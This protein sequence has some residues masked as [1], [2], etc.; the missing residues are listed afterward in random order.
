MTQNIST[1]NDLV[2]AN[3]IAD[4]MRLPLIKVA[5]K[6]KIAI[7]S[8]LIN[9]IIHKDNSD[10]IYK[11]F[12]PDIR[13][14]S[15]ML[16]EHEDPIGDEIH[17]PLTG[18]VHRYKNRVLIKLT[19]TCPI[20]CRF[21]FRREMVGKPENGILN[22][23]ELSDIYDYLKKHIEINEVIFTGGDPLILSPM[24]LGK[25]C[26]N[27]HEI[28]HIKTLRIHSRVVTALPKRINARLISALKQSEKTL[29]I[30]L[31]INHPNEL[32][33][34]AISKIQFLN[35]NNINLLSQTVLLAGVN[36]NATVLAQLMCQFI[37][38]GVRPYYIHHP[39]LARGT[40]HFQIDLS[41]VLTSI[42]S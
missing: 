12:V 27:L 11:Q 10:P 21:C 30:A 31:H 9:L 13:E 22:D 3:L 32:S 39:D 5:E 6:Y 38:Y 8:E 15:P 23:S 16:H 26:N 4:E 29:F 37:K 42:Q 14:I 34:N 18:L 28:S 20:Y 25:V 17:S 41:M 24:Y 36:D 7:S 35:E 19:Q 1:I 33:E 40:N 2:E